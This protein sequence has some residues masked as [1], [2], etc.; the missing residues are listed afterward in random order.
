MRLRA[1]RSWARFVLGTGL[2]YTPEQYLALTVAERGA[3]VDEL[4]HQRKQQRRRR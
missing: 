4:E 2:P 3:V 1:A